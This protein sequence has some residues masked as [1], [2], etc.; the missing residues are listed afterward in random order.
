MFLAFLFVLVFLFRFSFLG[1]EFPL[2]AVLRENK[3]FGVFSSRGQ[4][5]QGSCF[6]VFIG[7]LMA[8]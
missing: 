3:V 6:R 5:L 7:D 8:V 1:V 2:G 4:G